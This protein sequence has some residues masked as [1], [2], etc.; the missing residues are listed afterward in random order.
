MGNLRCRWVRD[1]L[2]L[3]AGDDLVGP[4]RRRVES[5]MVGCPECRRRRV[6]L[7]HAVRALEVA[8]ASSPARSDASSLWPDLARQI[9]ESRRP[10]RGPTFDFSFGFGFPPPRVR[11]GPAFGL[12]LGLIAAIG[13]T[14]AVR[15][16]IAAIRVDMAAN[17]L[18]IAT[19]MITRDI[20]QRPRDS[21]PSHDLPTPLAENVPPPQRFHD[22]SDPAPSSMPDP[23]DTKP[24]Y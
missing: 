6:M 13:A 23:R 14:V 8:S 20:A 11:F 2:P 5:H 12:F 21:A 10:H 19:P 18:P 9:R 17:A 15:N 22:E 1:R 4:D 3:L 7:G 16:Q 24:S